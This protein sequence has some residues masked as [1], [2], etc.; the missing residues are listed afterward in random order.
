MIHP[1]AKRIGATALTGV[2]LWA[3]AST[4]AVSASTFERVGA[5]VLASGEQELNSAVIAPDGAHAY[6]GTFTAPGRIVK[7]DLATFERVDALTLATGENVL[8]AGVIDPDGRFAYFGTY[9]DPGMVV[10][11]DLLTFERVAALTFEDEGQVL[12][13]LMAP[14]GS[15]AYFGTADS[16]GKIVKVDLS[17]F[18]PA[19]VLELAEALG[20][21]AA[22]DPAGTSAFVTT[23]LGSPGAL[24]KVDLASFE[25]V[26]SVELVADQQVGPA[27]AAVAV[28]PAG[29]AAYVATYTSPAKV[30]KVDLG[31]FT[32]VGTLTLGTGDEY[33]RTAVI[34]PAGAYAY[35]GALFN[36]VIRVDLTNFER[37]DAV[38][39]NSDEFPWSAV[40]DPIG[41]FMYL[42]TVA[43]SPGKV[44]KI[45]T[46]T[47]TP[48]SSDNEG[49]VTSGV[50]LDPNPASVVT[51]VAV[52][53]L[54]DDGSTGGSAISGAE[55]RIN[56]GAFVPLVASDGTFDD[57]AEGVDGTVPAASLPQADVYDVCVRGTDA[58]GNTGAVSCAT[59]A[60]YDPAAGSA[61]GAGWIESPAG[62]YA[63]DPD[64]SGRGRFGFVSRYKNGASVPDGQ[65]K[66][67]FRAGDLKFDSTGYEYLIVNQGGTRAQFKGT[68]SLNGVAGYGFMIWASTG[69]VD[70]F[71]IKIWDESEATVYD[72]GTDQTISGGKISIRAN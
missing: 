25:Q 68:G 67:V 59:L 4:G 56:D 11:V 23:R 10:K 57:G 31:T 69:D 9:T 52:S 63:A 45:A 19:G 15:F 50:V 26:D 71:R 41:G 65:A 55:Y 18:Q 48:P 47:P 35:F 5:I 28:D 36:R 14:D 30:L 39:L 49:P 24:L 27:L 70:T 53:A 51:D 38:A 29:T 16:P 20:G 40:M 64:A 72:N 12:S 8:Q 42:G 44:V 62:A 34:D 2:L 43:S 6:F 66:F 60:V 17:T 22:I 1:S 32:L 37:L 21:G 46:P 58:E 3:A 13:A 61:S 7:V 33:L 54:V